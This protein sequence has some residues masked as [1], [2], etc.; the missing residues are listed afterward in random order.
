MRSQSEQ[1]YKVNGAQ[2]LCDL[3]LSRASKCRIGLKAPYAN[4]PQWI[5]RLHLWTSP[6]LL[7]PRTWAYK[8]LS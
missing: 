5:D 2:T 7:G 6:A 3:V 4:R 8:T 1:P